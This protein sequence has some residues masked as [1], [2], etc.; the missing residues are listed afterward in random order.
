MCRRS[1]LEPNTLSHAHRPPR[2]PF[3]P[4][5]WSA[6]HRVISPTNW[7]TRHSRR[8]ADQIANASSRRFTDQEPRL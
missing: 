1:Q 8:F 3:S 6:R 4:I 2:T 7:P 5:K